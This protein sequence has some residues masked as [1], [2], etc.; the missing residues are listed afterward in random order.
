[1]GGFLKNSILL[2]L[3]VSVVM[4]FTL[5]SCHSGSQD[6][7]S[8]DKNPSSS[9]TGGGDSNPPPSGNTG[10]VASPS[11]PGSPATPPALPILNGDVAIFD[12][13]QEKIFSNP[14][15][16]ART[17]TVC[18]TGSAFGELD[19][20]EGISYDELLTESS[21]QHSVPRIGA[22][23]SESLLYLK[24]TGAP[25]VGGQMPQIG[26]FYENDSCEI[27]L[28][29]LWIDAGAGK[30]TTKEEA[31]NITGEE[32]NLNCDTI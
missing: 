1:M 28:V 15:V 13:I 27:R 31:M 24:L 8:P 5:I 29:R 22:S 32:H 21:P 9:S 6:L 26:G 23:A 3:T 2:K 10:N 18:H 25:G 14:E 11:Q 20:N 17:C 19:L 4:S 16:S 12:L 7:S 30:D